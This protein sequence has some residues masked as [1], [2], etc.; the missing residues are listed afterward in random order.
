MTIGDNVPTQRW[1]GGSVQGMATSHG[2]QNILDNSK[3]I[4]K[5]RFG[6][7]L[8]KLDLGTEP[9][10][11]GGQGLGPGYLL[12]WCTPLSYAAPLAGTLRLHSHPSTTPRRC[13]EAFLLSLPTLEPVLGA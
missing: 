1:L 11:L 2:R 8:E 7:P 10:F 4:Y 13:A 5:S 12:D 9:I 3:F 6:D